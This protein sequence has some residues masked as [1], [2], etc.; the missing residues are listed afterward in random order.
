M[1]AVPPDAISTH[2]PAF[3]TVSFLILPLSLS[4]SH[5]VQTLRK[6]ALEEYLAAGLKE[7]SIVYQV[8]E[9]ESVAPSFYGPKLFPSTGL[10]RC[11]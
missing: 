2:T 5:D 4:L 3:I 1:R 6:E 8:S 9:R 10:L 11:D 7:S